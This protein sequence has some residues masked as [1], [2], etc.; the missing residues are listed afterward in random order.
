LRRHSLLGSKNR[1]I[2]GIFIYIHSCNKVS[3]GAS[4]AI[5]GAEEIHKR[6]K[7]EIILPDKEANGAG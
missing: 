2:S 1:I 6:K 4:S 7:K 5:L 3:P